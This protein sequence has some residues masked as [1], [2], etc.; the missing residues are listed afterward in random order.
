MI[1]PFLPEGSYAILIN[2]MLHPEERLGRASDTGLLAHG[3]RLLYAHCAPS[4]PASLLL[5]A[6]PDVPPKGVRLLSFAK[7][8]TNCTRWVCRSFFSSGTRW[9]ALASGGRRSSHRW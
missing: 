6:L 1:L 5:V 3:R 4:A 9:I 8:Y 2:Y 7:S